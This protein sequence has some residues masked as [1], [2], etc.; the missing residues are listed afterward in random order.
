MDSAKILVIVLHFGSVRD[1]VECLDSLRRSVALPF[2]IFIVNNASDKDVEGLLRARYSDIIY[3]NAGFDTGFA[4]GNNIGLRFGIES[5]YDYALL[6]NNDTIAE[7]DFLQPLVDLLERD[8]TVGLAGPAIY[9]YQDKKRL[10][11]CGGRI[12]W[13]NGGLGGQTCLPET[14]SECLDVDYL[15]GTCILVRIK[16]LQGIGLM[17][18]EYFLGVEEADWAIKARRAGFRVV[19][20]PR[21]MLLHKVGVSSQYTPELIY[22]G[23]RNRFLFIRRQFPVPISWFLICC[24]LGNELR[25][26]PHHRSLC[27]RAF[28][29]HFK[30][31]RILRSHLQAARP[32]TQLG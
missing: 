19:S 7:E 25:R 21:S 31:R 18:E 1:T 29:D 17:S 10:W 30:Y 2:K 20:C 6:L 16:S 11:S 24:V 32:E 3:R 5:G 28:R 9:Y 23:V 22:N 4:A 15:P 13:W 8:S 12:T 27:W 26:H 14:R